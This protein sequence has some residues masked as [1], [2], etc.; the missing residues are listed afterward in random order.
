MAPVECKI[1]KLYA[2][3][4][5][6][7]SML[8]CANCFR[9]INQPYSN[10]RVCASNLRVSTLCYFLWWILAWS[11]GKTQS[12]GSSAKYFQS[13]RSGSGAEWYHYSTQWRMASCYLSWSSDRADIL[14]PKW[15]AFKGTVPVDLAKQ[16]N[17]LYLDSRFSQDTPRYQVCYM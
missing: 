10:C 17:I 14:F 8:K 4:S 9:R 15:I 16:S 13:T 6:N 1:C 3:K 5:A 7:L 11:F 12:R 2:E